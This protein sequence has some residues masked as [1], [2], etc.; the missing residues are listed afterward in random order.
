MQ[1]VGRLI[2]SETDRGVVL[3]ADSRFGRQNYEELMPEWWKPV[4]LAHNAKE[5]SEIVKKFWDE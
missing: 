5:V 2:R 1:A 4:E 3:L